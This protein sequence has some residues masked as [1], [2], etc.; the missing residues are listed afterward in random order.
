MK[1]ELK[2]GVESFEMVDGPFAG[3]AFVKGRVYDEIP[4]SEKNKFTKVEAGGP[5]SPGSAEASKGQE[6]SDK[7]ASKGSGTTAAKKTEKTTGGDA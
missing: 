2:P 7:P 6:A 5:S 4:P 1:H 3:K